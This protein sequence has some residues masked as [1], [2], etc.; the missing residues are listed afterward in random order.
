MQGIRSIYDRQSKIWY[1]FIS[2]DNAKLIWLLFAFFTTVSRFGPLGVDRWAII[3]LAR[4][5]IAVIGVV[6]TFSASLLEA[7]FYSDYGAIHVALVTAG[8]KFVL[9]DNLPAHC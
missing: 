2:S 9:F 8:L 3:L 5:R 6:P 7:V 4:P 1:P